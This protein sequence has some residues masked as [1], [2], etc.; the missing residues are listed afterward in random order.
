MKYIILI[1]DGASGHPLSQYQNQTSLQ[2]ARTPN[3]D[4]MAE[5]GEVGLTR[6]VPPDMEPSSAV[7]C[8]S[9]LGYNPQEYYTGRASI[10]AFSLGVPTSP[11]SS[12]FRCNLVNIQNGIMQSYNGGDIQSAQA[13]VLIDALNRALGSKTVQFFPGINYRHIL[14]L[15]DEGVSLK[16]ITTAPHDISD[17]EIATHL[18]KG[19]GSEEL[20]R[21]MEASTAIFRDHQVNLERVARGELPISQVWLFWGAPSLDKWPSMQQKYGLKGALSSAVSLLNGIGMLM[22]M[23]ILSIAGVTDTDTN[24]YARQMSE[25]L[26]ALDKHDLVVVHVEAPD[27][28]G[29]IGSFE[30]KVK[31]I[32]DIDKDMVSAIKEYAQ[33]HQVRVLILP[34]HPTPVALKTHTNEAVPYLMW[35][36]RIKGGLARRFTEAEADKSGIYLENGYNMMKKFT[37][38]I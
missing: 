21:L 29:H 17:K 37:E 31:A 16:A 35:G 30:R 28:M 12:L 23:D 6:N 8:L 20:I 26:L 27:E 25:S 38:G 18:P 13:S 11:G 7:A 14:R 10:E 33:N 19:M 36:E 1:I 2:I 9:L 24:D 15:D 5:E 22:G 34:D 4:S 32:E 3:L